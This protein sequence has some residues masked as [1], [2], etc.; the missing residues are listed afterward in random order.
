MKCDLALLQCDLAL[1]PTRDEVDFSVLDSRLD[2]E[3]SNQ[4]NKSSGI[5]AL[6]VLKVTLN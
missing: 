5:C 4:E 1:P 3:Y 6:P 2:L